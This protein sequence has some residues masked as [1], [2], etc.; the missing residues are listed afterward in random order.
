MPFKLPAQHCFVAAA[1]MEVQHFLHSHAQ[2]GPAAIS[3]SANNLAKGM[4]S[5]HKH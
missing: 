2:G 3:K 1:T 5:F 4:S